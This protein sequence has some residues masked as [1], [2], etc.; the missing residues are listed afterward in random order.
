M[1]H[2]HLAADVTDVTEQHRLSILAS[3]ASNRESIAEKATAH[4]I[5]KLHNL[6]LDSRHPGWQVL[7][8]CHFMLQNLNATRQGRVCHAASSACSRARHM[9]R[10]DA[11]IVS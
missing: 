1:K 5:A 10:D 8:R 3:C 7:E 6:R 2:T 4:L 9:P 11:S